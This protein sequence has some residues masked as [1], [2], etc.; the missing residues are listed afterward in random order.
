MRKIHRTIKQI[1]V[2]VADTRGFVSL[3]TGSG[4][5]E[6]LPCRSQFKIM[7]T[8]SFYVITQMKK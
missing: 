8:K 7:N 4:G 5:G 6:G 3:S 1:K 2:L